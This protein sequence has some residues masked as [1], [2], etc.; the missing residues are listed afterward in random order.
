[1]EPPLRPPPKRTDCRSEKEFDISWRQWV[2]DAVWALLLADLKRNGRCAAHGTR[3]AR[4]SVALA[5]VCSVPCVVA[6]AYAAYRA[7]AHL[8][9]P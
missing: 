8:L 1:M 6:G 9:V 4:N 3:I 2:A 7:I 5:V